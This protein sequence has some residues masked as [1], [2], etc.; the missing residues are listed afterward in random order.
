MTTIQEL[1]RPAFRGLPAGL[2]PFETIDRVAARLGLP[3]SHLAKLDANEN[4]YG[5]S[6]A[7]V[8][9][10]AHHDAWN[11]YPDA[12]QQDARNALAQYV[13]V[14]PRHILLFNGGD[15]LIGMLCHLFVSP[16]DNIVE[17]APSFEM[18]GWYARSYGADLR[19]APRQV[20]SDYAISLAG[21][22]EVTD[23]HTK[24][25]L[26]CNPNNPTGTF[27]PLVEILSLLD[28]GFIVMVDEAYVEFCGETVAPLVTR[29][30]NLV[31]LRTMSKWAGLAGLRVG[32][33]VASASIVEQL[34]KVKDPFNVNAAGQM[35]TIASVQDSAYL[36]DNVRRIVVERERLFAA[37]G[38]FPF[39]HVYPSRANFLLC[40]VVHGLAQALRAHLERAGILVRLFDKPTL[41]NAIRVTVGTPSHTDRIVAALAQWQIPRQSP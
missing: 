36:L 3:V 34:W 12:S 10:L 29:Y 26:L 5:P 7:A 6:P 8:A 27:T 25:L 40:R 17:C 14:D 41:P 13:G 35:A 31:V 19:S 2:V 32:Y 30:E 9:S 24:V 21:I 23:D 39:L 20:Q 33:A 22:R 11:L 15:E 16:G 18:Y 28:S 37:L 4:V 1:I 38:Q